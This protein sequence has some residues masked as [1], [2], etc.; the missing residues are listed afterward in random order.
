VNRL[1]FHVRKLLGLPVDYYYTRASV[2]AATHLPAMLALGRVFPVKRVLEFGA[3]RFSTL[4]F[5]NRAIFPQV[6][7]VHSL[8][9]DAE[10]KRMVETMAAGDPRLRLDLIDTDVGRHA[11]AVDYAAYDLVFIDNG[12]TG[13]EREATIREVARR[14]APGN[15]VV[16]HDFEEPR[17]A[18]AGR[19]YERRFVFDAYCPHTGLLWKGG[20]IERAA[21]AELKRLNRACATHAK[22][23]EPDDIEGWIR[24]VRA[25]P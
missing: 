1:K 2:P 19:M 20:R 10:W 13:N 16:V 18:R 12:P 15:L 6:E 5:L 4:T 11:A 9:T 14:H 7:Q 3:G 23:L 21:L 25:M 8:E 24:T 17:Y 22:H